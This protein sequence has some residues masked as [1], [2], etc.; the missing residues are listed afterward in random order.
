MHVHGRQSCS[1]ALY[2][3]QVRLKRQVH[4]HKSNRPSIRCVRM[5][6]KV[7]MTLNLPTH[8]AGGYALF[9]TQD[10]CA[11]KPGANAVHKGSQHAE[12]GGIAVPSVHFAQHGCLQT[13]NSHAKAAAKT[14][15]SFACCNSSVGLLVTLQKVPG[16]YASSIVCSAGNC[17]PAQQPLLSNLR[18]SLVS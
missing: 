9:L 4:G 15:P 16:S 17:R 3:G 14:L 5:Y 1:S 8:V 6:P 10:L 13:R 7:W 12:Y 11:V 2:V 18:C